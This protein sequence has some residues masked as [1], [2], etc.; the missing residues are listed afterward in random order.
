M[1]RS[2]KLDWCP[3]NAEYFGKTGPFDTRLTNDGLINNLK[4]IEGPV[5]VVSVQR[6]RHANSVNS[7]YIIIGFKDGLPQ[8]V[9]IENCL[10]IVRHYIRHPL[11]CFTCHLFGHGH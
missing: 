4:I 8:R 6:L 9:E 1:T 3:S 5:R 2:A 11:R 7:E 10:Y